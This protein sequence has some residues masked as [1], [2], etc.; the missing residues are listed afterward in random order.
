[1]AIYTIELPSTGGG[2]HTLALMDVNVDNPVDGSLLRYNGA[3][4]GFDLNS[5]TTVQTITDGGNF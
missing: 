4:D 5:S 2:Q 1:M 3:T